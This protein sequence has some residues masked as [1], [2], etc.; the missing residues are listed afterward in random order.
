M[1]DMVFEW[2]SEKERENVRDHGVSFETAKYIF[3]D[4]LRIER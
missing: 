2:D 1:I 3:N 4:P